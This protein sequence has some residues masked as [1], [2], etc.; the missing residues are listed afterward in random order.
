[1]LPNDAHLHLLLNHIPILGSAFALLILGYGLLRKSDDV[2]RLGLLMFFVIGAAAVAV[3][4][5]GEPAEE[6]VEDLAGVSHDL[7]E[8]HEDAAKFATIVTAAAGVL[9]LLSLLL[10][11]G[12]RS[13][14]R[15][16][17]LLT[18]VVGLAGAVA[19]ARTGTLGGVIRHTEIR[20]GAAAAGGEDGGEDEGRRGRGRGGD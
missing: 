16:A 19:M 4:F 15:A 3:Y 2:I 12:R 14:A 17:T 20:D 7:I 11:R 1:M 10:H 9:A 5:T 13:A 18:L 6:M 8:E